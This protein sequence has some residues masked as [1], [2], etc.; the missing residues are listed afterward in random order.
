[1]AELF[2]DLKFSVRQLWSRPGFSLTAVLVI[3]LGIGAATAI[4]SVL[5]TLVIRAL[6][7]GE[8]DRIVT[9]W[10]NNRESGLERDD[11]A[12]ANFFDWR[13]QGESFEAIAAADPYSLDL[14]GVERPEVIFSARVTEDFFEAFGTTALHGRTFLPE[15]YADGKFV[16]IGERLWERRFGADQ[17]LVGQ[18][19]ELDGEPYTLVGV[20]PRSFNPHFSPSVE[21]RDAWIPLVLQGWE[22]YTRGSR[23]WNV[24]AML[25]PGVTIAQAQAEMDAISGRLAEDY[26]ETN[27]TI[28]AN[29]VPLRDH[30]VGGARTALLVLQGAVVFLLLIA[31]AN[32]ASLLLARGTERESEFAIRA[33]LGAGRGRLI[34]QLLTESAALALI[35]GVIGILL[36]NWTVDLIVALGPSELPRMDEI[37]VD[38]RV[39]GFAVS[40]AVGTALLFGILPS[41]HFSRP[42]LQGSMKDIR[43]VTAG[44][45]RRR[46]RNG[47]VVVEVALS[48]VLVVGAGLL[49]RSFVSLLGVDPGFEKENVAALQ[50]F[51]YEDD[52]TPQER[53]QYFAEALDRIRAL[54]G[55]QSAGVVSAMPLIE[56][57]IAIQQQFHIEGRALARP[58]DAPN[59]FL[60]IASEDYF[61]TMR[62]PV[63]DGRTF[64]DSDNADGVRVAV[65]TES[66]ARRHWP[67]ESPIGDRVQLVDDDEG[68]GA[69][70][71]G[72]EGDAGSTPVSWEIVGVVGQVRHDGLDHDS[73]P[74]IFL[75]AAQTSMG[76]MTF[77]ART[78]GDPAA[79]I[80]PIQS[81]IWALDP[82]QTF[83]RTA[84]LEELLAKSVA[85]RRFN[86]WLLGTFAVIALV[87]AAVGIYGVISYTTRTRTH[88][89][90]IRM[91]LGARNDDVLRQ[92]MIRGIQLT[93]IGIAI[94]F[95][96]SLGLT[97]L[98]SSLLFGISA[99][100]PL[101]FVGVAL[102][103]AVVA[104]AATYLPARRATEVDPVVALRVE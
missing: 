75:P 66:L 63:L 64:E 81:E 102:L 2:H 19:I 43:T 79:Y 18:A 96:G 98:M 99:T 38:G 25:K 77:V 68:A 32:V 34:R 50:I 55:V 11:V 29:V 12:P 3:A 93:G 57:N 78:D 56:A 95:A 14:T 48:V 46:I 61:R 5:D 26:P 10:E 28:R 51:R 7:Y 33:A 24:V 76:S 52:E 39:L 27:E 70:E 103:L 6:P 83:Y 41:L 1:M 8:A 4:F 65:I 45:A 71:G 91:A 40:L 13:E 60:A 62:I 49:A 16:V 44:S 58:Q 23:W 59:T 92:V 84:T 97:R 101:T 42:D 30:L 20:V 15:D 35:G 69:D 87:L 80:Q 54:P 9:I 88:E 104:L 73:R 31:C 89:I 74:E 47:M 67:N 100:D 17:G 86:L 21:E 90:G 53:Q 36:A 94:G 37:R 22:Q 72:D 82:L 85:A